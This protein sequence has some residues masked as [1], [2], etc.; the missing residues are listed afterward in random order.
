MRFLLALP[1]VRQTQLLA[2]EKMR[3][4]SLPKPERMSALAQL[5]AYVPAEE[6][7]AAV[8]EVLSLAVELQHG[9]V[10]LSVAR[11]V[12]AC[13]LPLLVEVVVGRKQQIKGDMVRLIEQVSAPLRQ[14]VGQ[15]LYEK[16]RVPDFPQG[17]V[18]VIQL[19]R[20]LEGDALADAVHRAETVD[21][22]HVLEQL[23]PAAKQMTVAQLDLVYKRL[24]TAGSKAQRPL[25][26]SL[27]TAIGVVA[28]ELV[29]RT[30]QYALAMFEYAG[31]IMRQRSADRR[32]FMGALSGLAPLLLAMGPPGVGDRLAREILDVGLAWP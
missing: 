1:L 3:V 21:S 13:H 17:N 14:E 18:F 31:R 23:A 16:V 22:T 11:W 10:A 20:F 27:V 25:H 6:R 30:P 29:R 4:H 2:A 7:S 32:E 28:G 15:R 12:E 8:T 19:S 24:W 9:N 5:C 26:T